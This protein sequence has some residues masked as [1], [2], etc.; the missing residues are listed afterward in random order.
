MSVKQFFKSTTL[1]CLLTLL[2]VLL[3]S[4]IFLTVMNSLL[5]VTDQEKFDRA[6]NKIYG[7]SVTTEKVAVAQ[8]NSDATIDEAYKVL[9]DGNYLIKATGKGGFDNGTVTCWVVVVVEKGKITGINKVVIDSNKSQSYISNIND[10]FLNGFKNYTGAKFDPEVGF[11]KTG[12]TFSAGAICNAVNGA[13]DYVNS[14]WL[15]NV[16]ENKFEGFLF[17]EYID[18]DVTDYTIDEDGN[19]VFAIKTKKYPEANGFKVNIV[20][21]ADGRIVSYEIVENGS[22]GGFGNSMNPSIVDG[23]LFVGKDIADIKA[24]LNDGITFPS[25]SNEDLKT[26]ATKSNYLCVCAAAFATANYKQASDLEEVEVSFEGSEYASFINTEATT[27]Q[28]NKKTGD[29]VFTVVTTD[30]TYDRGRAKAFTVK[31]TVDS[32]GVITSYVIVI[33]GSAPA[34]YADRMAPEVLDGSLFVGKDLAGILAILE[35]GVEYPVTDP[36]KVVST[37]ATQSNHLCLCAAAFAAENYK[38]VGGQA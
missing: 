24:L 10:K 32:T 22:T 35:S 38:L 29:I 19:V 30:A 37:G 6:I 18:T 16:T 1:K 27:V 20:V 31:V 15:G 11:V 17:T 34:S 13:I 14:H 2:C 23:T 12:A 8:Y 36:D 5:K 7:K 21:G 9:D 28:R 33:N 3:V 25:G 26:G 4:G